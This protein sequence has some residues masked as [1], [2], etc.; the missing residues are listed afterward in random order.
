[1]PYLKIEM[2]AGRSRD[3]KSAL[4]KAI[5]EAFVRHA[6]CRTEDVQIVIHEIKRGDWAIG[7]VLGDDG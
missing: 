1:M 7:G 3:Q 5:T 4:T 2:Y 6:G